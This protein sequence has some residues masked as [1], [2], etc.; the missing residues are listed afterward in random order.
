MLNKSIDPYIKTMIFFAVRAGLS[1][2]E[3]RVIEGIGI[4]TCVFVNP[5]TQVYWIIDDRI[6]DVDPD[7]KTKLKHLLDMLKQVPLRQTYR[8]SDSAH[9]CLVCFDERHESD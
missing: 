7:G 2:S 1:G 8:F 9:R 5:K 3:K 6:Y 4:V